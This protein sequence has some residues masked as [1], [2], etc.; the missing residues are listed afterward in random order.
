MNVTY[1][2]YLQLNE[3]DE[4]L[5]EFVQ[6]PESRA[7]KLV[8]GW[9][10]DISVLYDNAMLNSKPIRDDKEIDLTEIMREHKLLEVEI[11]LKVPE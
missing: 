2:L 4:E 9:L 6:I 11:N 5:P 7:Y 1:K 8:M 10:L 3:T